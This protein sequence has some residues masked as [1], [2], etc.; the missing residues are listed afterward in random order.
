MTAPDERQL[1]FDES[2]DLGAQQLY[3]EPEHR[4]RDL[5]GQ[6]LTAWQRAT[7][8]TVPIHGSYL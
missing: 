7:I 8:T 2:A 1:T 5:E 4:D 6:G 3:P